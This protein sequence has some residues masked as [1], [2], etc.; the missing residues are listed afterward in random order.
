VRLARSTACYLITFSMDLV[1]LISRTCMCLICS[2]FSI[3]SVS[4]R[5]SCASEYFF[6]LISLSNTARLSSSLGEGL[7]TVVN[8]AEICSLASMS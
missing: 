7:Y 6:Y 1:I 2:C 5:S 3:F 4:A 8:D